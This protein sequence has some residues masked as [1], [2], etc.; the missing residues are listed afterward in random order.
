M[1][2]TRP[3]LVL[4]LLAAIAIA[5]PAGAQEPK[6]TAIAADKVKWGPAPPALPPGAQAAVLLGD[7]GKEGP[8]VIRVKMPAGYVVPPH[9]HSKDEVLTVISGKMKADHGDKV[10]K[11][12]ALPAGSLMAMPA[13]MV[14]YAWAE[15]ASVIQVNGTGPFDVKYVDPKDDPRNKAAAPAADKKA[16]TKK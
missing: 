8:F 10:E 3:S 6:H 12:G 15:T 14:H 2:A 16:E 1:K 11:K 13:G 7:P 4:S 9:S 5:G